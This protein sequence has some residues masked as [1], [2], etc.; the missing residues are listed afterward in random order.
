MSIQFF[1]LLHLA[2]GEFSAVNVPTQDFLDQVNIYLNNAKTL[3]NSLREVGYKFTLLTNN[4]NLLIQSNENLGQSLDIS[5]IEFQTEIPSGIRFF[6]AHFKVDAFRYIS[7]LDL[8]Y[9]VMCDVDMV[10][11]KP[12]PLSLKKAQSGRIPLVYEIS[13]QVIPAYGHDVIIKDM[14]VI[15]GKISEGRWIGGEFIA[16]P[17]SFFRLLTEEIDFLL[18]NYFRNFD[19]LHHIG[20]EAYTSCAIQEIR[21]KGIF[22]GDAG[23]SG[24]V[25]RFWNTKVLHVQK[26]WQ[27]FKKVFLLH[28]PSDK[29]FLA[30]L[31]SLDYTLENSEDFFREYERHSRRS[32]TK[33]S[34]QRFVIFLKSL[35]ALKNQ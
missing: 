8:N 5:E 28:L 13:D 10:C 12:V 1:G 23:L 15:T 3:S 32:R 14:E 9:A 11:I 33:Q 16:G 25:G 2:P 18:P 24:I 20:D 17:S 7:T 27:Y 31:G 35:I 26:P 19:N 22:V 34:L 29:R 21:N 4:A 30:G 6:S